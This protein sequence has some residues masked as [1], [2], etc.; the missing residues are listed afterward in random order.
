[1]VLVE[2]PS[3]NGLRNVDALAEDLA[4][5][6]GLAV[7][8]QVVDSYQDAYQALCLGHAA[9]AALNAFSYLA[10]REQGCAEGLLV[11]E[12]DGETATQGQLVAAAAQVFSL[13]NFR[14]Q[15][16]CRPGGVTT[17]GWILPG[18]AMRQEQIDPFTQLAGIVEAT[19]DADVL[20]RIGAAECLVGATAAGAEGTLPDP[21]VVDVIQ[22]LPSVPNEAI[23]VSA[24]LNDAIRAVLSDALADRADDLA[25]SLRVDAF[26][27]MDDAAYDD[28]AA[29]IAGAGVDVTALG[30]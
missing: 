27:S 16:F 7:V 8:I 19:D 22:V 11:A 23:A 28:L 5:E 20:R 26:V 6:A 9:A 4:D 17:N 15:V 13:G 1:V 3:G 25:Q 29:L 30:E 10:A 12:L 18:L 21:A 2:P 24:G 14:G